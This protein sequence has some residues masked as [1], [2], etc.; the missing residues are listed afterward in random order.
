MLYAGGY[1]KDNQQR[2]NRQGGGYRRNDNQSGHWKNRRGGQGGGYQ[3]K[4]Y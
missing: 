2:G 4:N 3:Q 1:D